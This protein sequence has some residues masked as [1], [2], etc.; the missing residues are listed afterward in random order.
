MKQTRA[1]SRHFRIIECIC[2]CYR[3][4]ELDAAKEVV[5]RIRRLALF[6]RPRQA[7]VFMDDEGG[8]Y[9]FGL[10]RSAAQTM[11]GKH[12]EWL[13]G[14]FTHKASA[15]DIAEDLEAMWN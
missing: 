5:E 4:H 11:L 15:E 14:M 8:V 6:H 3:G 13:V 7:Y 12:P 2:T 10:D 1:P 9:V